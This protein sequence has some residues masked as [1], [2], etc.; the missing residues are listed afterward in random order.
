MNAIVPVKPAA[1][2]ALDFEGEAFRT[3]SDANG[4]PI[5][6]ATDL[7]RA[8]GYR[9]AGNL[10]RNLDADELTTQIV[11]GGLGE[12][13]EVLYIT[14]A[15]LYRALM[16]RR[17][18]KKLHPQVAARI[19][20]FQRWVTHDVL[21]S[22]RRTGSYTAPGTPSMAVGL[23]DAL[24]DPE[25]VL[26]LIA[27]HAQATLAARAEAE[28]ERSAHAETHQHLED[29]SHLLDV[30]SRRAE[31]TGRALV[32]ATQRIAAQEPV[33]ERHR[34]MYEADGALCVTD[35]AN[36]MGV[37][38][39]EL[40]AFLR[41]REHRV[42]WLYGGEEGKGPERP[43]RERV[44]RKQMRVRLVRVT[45]SDGTVEQVG[46][47][48]ITPKGV[49]RLMIVFPHWAAEQARKK[50]GQPVDLFAPPEPPPEPEDA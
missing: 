37:P 41:D 27:H 10:A 11:S 35:A 26:A 18:G 22:I 23:L 7:A 13:R 45:H 16:L 36:V 44:K 25:Q 31:T 43:F 21:P 24:R 40:Y 6:R 50:A 32:V 34:R 29:T 1:T 33:V 5:F 15:G 42:P 46:Q 38:R 17:T 14:E 9:D 28:A 4:A 30:A 8:L 19:E 12:D 49:D 39:G 20:R 48:M 3:S 47:P 2:Q